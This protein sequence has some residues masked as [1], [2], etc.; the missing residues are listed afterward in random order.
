[1]RFLDLEKIPESSDVD[2]D[3]L[4]LHGMGTAD[5]VLLHALTSPIHSH[6]APARYP[7]TVDRVPLTQTIS[8]L[9]IRRTCTAS[10]CPKGL[11]GMFDLAKFNTTVPCDGVLCAAENIFGRERGAL[12]VWTYLKFGVSLTPFV[13]VAGDRYGFSADTIRAVMMALASTPN[14]LR[15]KAFVNFSFFRA[16]R[17]DDYRT[18][19]GARTIA[20]NSGAVYNA[21]DKKTP[22]QQ[23]GLFIHEIAHQVGGSDMGG[24]DSS[25]EWQVASGW[26]LIARGNQRYFGRDPWISKYQQTDAFEDFAE[27]YS[28]FRLNPHRLKALSPGRFDFMKAQVFEGVDYLTNLCEGSR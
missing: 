19:T 28:L 8:F 17:N 5:V 2:L 15:A 27:T 18:I 4:R 20:T 21:I 7:I 11:R 12:M 25:P 14:R 6:G 24:P 26:K 23:I 3:G 13:N 10:E 9:K 16:D 22:P 1:M